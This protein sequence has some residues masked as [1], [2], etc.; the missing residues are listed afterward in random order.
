LSGEAVEVAIIGVCVDPP[1]ARAGDVG[2]PW[3]KTVAQQPEQPKDHITVGAG[4]GH[5]LGGV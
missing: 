2:Q 1:E 4:V 5:D 3:A